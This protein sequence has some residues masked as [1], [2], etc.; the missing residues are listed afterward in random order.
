MI[1]KSGMDMESIVSVTFSEGKNGKV[2]GLITVNAT[3]VSS[4][5][6]YDSLNNKIDNSIELMDSCDITAR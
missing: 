2:V 4:S 6:K 1:S 3:P 5:G